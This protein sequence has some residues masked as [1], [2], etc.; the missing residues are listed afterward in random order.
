VH[1]GSITLCS[2]LMKQQVLFRFCFVLRDIWKHYFITR[3]TRWWSLLRHCA[4]RRKFAGS[5]PD[6]VTGIFYLHNPSGRSMAL[7]LTHE[8]KWVLEIFP[9]GKGGR[10]IG[11]TTLP[12]SCADFIEIWERQPPGTPRVCPGLCYLPRIWTHRCLW[13]V[14]LDTSMFRYTLLFYFQSQKLNHKQQSVT[15]VTATM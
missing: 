10:C 9:G 8:Q 13:H 11:L 5:I 7:R 6:G 12:L 1:S 4:T 15:T 14:H 2:G 3:G